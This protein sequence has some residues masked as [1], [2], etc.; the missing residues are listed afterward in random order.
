MICFVSGVSCQIR[1]SALALDNS[2]P[3]MTFCKWPIYRQH[4]SAVTVSQKVCIPETNSSLFFGL[5]TVLRT[6]FSSCHKFS[7]EAVGRSTSVMSRDLSTNGFCSNILPLKCN[8]VT[9]NLDFKYHNIDFI[10]IILGKAFQLLFTHL[11]KG[12]F[13]R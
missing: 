13:R 9:N 2:R 10:K 7:L 6:F 8:N 11:A 4:F 12:C 1:R 5:T 3:G